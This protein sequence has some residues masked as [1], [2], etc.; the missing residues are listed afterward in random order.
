MECVRIKKGGKLS[1]T[2]WDG[3]SGQYVTVD[4]TDPTF[5]YLHMPCELDDDVTLRD[6]LVILKNDMEMYSILLRN[7]VDELVEEGLA[8]SVN[9]SNNLDYLELYW[10]FEKTTYKGAT[11]FSGHFFPQF[12]GWGTWDDPAAGGGKGGI[13]IEF[14]PVNELA[15]VPLRLREGVEITHNNLDAKWSTLAELATQEDPAVVIQACPYSLFHILYGIVWE[16]S[17]C[18]SPKDRDIR[19]KELRDTVEKVKGGCSTWNI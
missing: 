6:V 15:D 9:K 2:S 4:V 14:T 5:L 7:W 13:A 12:H 16:L 1:K 18:G 8:E 3:E 19:A 10:A 11:E 17:F